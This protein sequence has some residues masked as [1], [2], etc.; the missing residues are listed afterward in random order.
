M[1]ETK[2]GKFSVILP[3]SKEYHSIKRE[4]WGS[5]IYHFETEK[6]SP[7]IMDIGSHIG[8][9]ILYFK[10]IYPNS[11]IFAFEPNP[12]SFSILEENIF[13]NNLEDVT[14]INK[15]IWSQNGNKALY[16]DNTP[17]G[18]NS[19]TSFLEKSWTGKEQT[20]K[21]IVETT[22]LDKYLYDNVDMLKIDTEG[23]ELAILKANESILK[24]VS[25]ILIEYH[26]VKGSKPEDLLNILKRYFHID[27]YFDGKPS[28]KIEK[29]KLLTIKGKNSK[30]S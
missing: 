27:I 10:A 8:I 12:I 24:R 29:E 25:N 28:K 15:A 13:R 7:L 22:T 2:L 11:K 20:K 9:S 18:W 30:N 1:Q 21:V 5:D 14:A 23:S 26:P 4:V 6:D 3:N 17:N 19:N 16:I